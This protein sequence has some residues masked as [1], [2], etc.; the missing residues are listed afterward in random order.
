MGVVMGTPDASKC[1]YSASTS[2]TTKTTRRPSATW[3]RMCSGLKVFSPVR[4]KT[5][6]NP[7]SGRRI[8]TKP[9]LAI[10][11]LNPR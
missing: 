5:R 1:A 8:E 2:S 11:S 6:L 9:S 3:P 4:R 10:S 7:A